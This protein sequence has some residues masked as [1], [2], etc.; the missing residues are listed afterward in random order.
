[1]AEGGGGGSEDRSK[2]DL[3]DEASPYRVEEFRS[4]G[5]AAQSREVSGMAALLATG[6]TLYVLTPRMGAQMGEFMREVFR[7]DL[8]SRLDLGST[9]IL[10]QFLAK[11]VKL[12]TALA[13]PVC[14]AGF[15]VGVISSFAQVGSI[16]SFDPITP[17]L[18]KINPLK[19]LQRMASMKQAIDGFRL[20]FKMVIV[21]AVSYGLVKSEVLRSPMLLGGEP[22]NVLASYAHAAKVI[23]LTLVSILGTFAAIDYIMQKREFSQNVRLTKQEAKQESREKEGDPAIKARIRAVQR[24]V[25]RRRM[26]SAVKT[27]DVIVTNPT[28]IAIAIKYDR[29]SM[30]APK[31]VAKGADL[32]AQR[33]KALA[34][35]AGIPTVE[36]VPLAR[37]LY[38]AVK[39]N[40]YVPRALYQA[41]AEVLAYVY[42][43]KRRD[44]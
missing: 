4:K 37:T 28:H 32:I 24:E 25:S 11:A 1:M 2:D 16:F 41:V 23:F 9:Q 12:M 10:N 20:V 26:M 15:V 31:V 13:L 8:S 14:A 39:L 40:Q 43:L 36:N 21:V 22:V 35:E 17:D 5:Q 38:K 6:I 18:E 7:T 3:S 19:G 34:A 29:E 33:I 42:R 27:A 44:Y 30:A